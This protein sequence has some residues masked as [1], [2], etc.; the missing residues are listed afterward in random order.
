MSSRMLRPLFSTPAVAVLG[1]PGG[2]AAQE[3]PRG[4][5][6]LSAEEAIENARDRYYAPD[7]QTVRYCPQ[8]QIEERTDGNVIV[9]C[10]QLGPANPFLTRQ[11]PRPRMDQTADGGPAPPDFRRPPCVP[12]LLTVC[13]P[14]LGGTPP[15][16]L[17]IDLSAIPEA[18]PGSDAARY[19]EEYGSIAM[20]AELSNDERTAASAVDAAPSTAAPG[21]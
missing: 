9:V 1:W 5:E 8:G 6:P 20:P 13:V 10:R 3:E 14:G 19:A 7:V 16:P 11:G 18:P 17:L 21:N 4:S 12:S 2:L 15:R